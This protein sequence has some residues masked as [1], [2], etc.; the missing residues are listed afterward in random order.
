MKLT[1]FG[2]F[3]LNESEL[4]MFREIFENLL[5]NYFSFNIIGLV[6]FTSAKLKIE[7]IYEYFCSV[8]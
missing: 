8:S 6:I 7:K 5:R 1:I 3:T 2:E 4:I